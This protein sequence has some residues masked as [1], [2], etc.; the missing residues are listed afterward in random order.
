M[1]LIQILGC[2][3]FGECGIEA[4]DHLEKAISLVQ[5]KGNRG[6][7]LHFSRRG[8]ATWNQGIKSDSQ[9]SGFNSCYRWH[10]L[11]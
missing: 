8:G 4:G 9:D 3:P 5:V 11:P 7:D 6:L 1:Y 10:T 2:T